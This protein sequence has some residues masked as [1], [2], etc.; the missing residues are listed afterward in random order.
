M[1]HNV[2]FGTLGL[3]N[4]KCQRCNEELDIS[5]IDIDCDLTSHNPFC[6]DLDI[7]CYECEKDNL[8]KFEIKNISNEFME[9]RK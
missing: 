9:N 5:E 6:F 4:L 1:G 3:C 2:D 7:Q 8:F